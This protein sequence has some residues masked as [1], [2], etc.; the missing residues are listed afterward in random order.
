MK[1]LD[2]LAMIL[3]LLPHRDKVTFERGEFQ[4]TGRTIDP[5]GIG[6]RDCV[7]GPVPGR[8]ERGFRYRISNN[9]RRGRIVYRWI[10]SGG[11][12]DFSVGKFA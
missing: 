5:A 12:F 9:N 11:R 7:F 1:S 6:S 4:N 8:P 10:A 2:F 3:F